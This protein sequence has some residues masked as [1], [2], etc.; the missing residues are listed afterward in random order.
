LAAHQTSHS[1]PR[2][3]IFS[4]TSRKKMGQNPVIRISVETCL[5]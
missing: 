1:D 3:G 4:T 2:T 5:S